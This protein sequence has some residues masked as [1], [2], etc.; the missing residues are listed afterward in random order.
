MSSVFPSQNF[1]CRKENFTVGEYIPFLANFSPWGG[2]RH[3]ENTE[4]VKAYL[5]TLIT[6]LGPVRTTP[7]GVV[8]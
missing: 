4:S 3:T 2:G 8:E 7:A 5:S 6:Q 1:I